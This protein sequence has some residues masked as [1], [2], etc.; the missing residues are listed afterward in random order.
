M[1]QAPSKYRKGPGPSGSGVKTIQQELKELKRNYERHKQRGKEYRSGELPMDNVEAKKFPEKTKKYEQGI[2]DLEK[3]IKDM[4]GGRYGFKAKKTEPKTDSKKKLP[5]RRAMP[6]KPK[7]GPPPGVTAPKP[8]DPDY[9][10][11]TPGGPVSGV[12]DQ[13]ITDNPRGASKKLP[14]DQDTLDKLSE[15]DK[16]NAQGKINNYKSQVEKMN[17]ALGSLTPRSET[18]SKALDK[19]VNNILGADSKIKGTFSK[20]IRNIFNKL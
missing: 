1:S 12:S 2:K 5:R 3:R 4:S 20:G 19:Q 11:R 17:E 9:R 7:A 8:G 6:V 16:L 13:L 14:V 18:A 10:K 15:L